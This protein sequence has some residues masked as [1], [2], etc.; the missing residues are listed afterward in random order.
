MIKTKRLLLIITG[1]MNETLY[2]S[3]HVTRPQHLRGT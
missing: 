3:D 1:Y 2:H